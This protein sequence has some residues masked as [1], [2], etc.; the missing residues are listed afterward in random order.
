MTALQ[1]AID[2]AQL[3][4]D[5]NYLSQATV[6]AAFDALTQAIADFGAAKIAV[7]FDGL[8]A[9]ITEAKAI[10]KGNYNTATWNALQTAI[11]DAET[12]RGTQYVTQT[13]VDDAL[14]ALTA[15]IA[16]LRNNSSDGGGATYYTVTFDTDGGSAVK[17]VSVT[18]NGKVTKPADPT[19]DGY[20][21]GGW[22]ADKA[23]T[24]EFDFN[25]GITG[26]I[27]IYAK[28]TE[29][30]TVTPPEWENP[31]TDVKKSDWFYGDVE[32]VCENNLM[33]GTSAD[34]FSPNANLTRGMIVTILY[35][36]EGEL[37]V[38]GLA[39]PFTDVAAGQYYTDAIKWAVENKIVEGYG[40]GKFGPSDSITREQLAAILYRYMNYK[41]INLPV[42][43]QYIIFADEAD[44]S[45]YA[46]NAV[47]TFN[48]LGIIQGIGT[49]TAGQTIVN[50][51][52]NATRA[53]VAAMLHRFMKAIK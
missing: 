20:T 45:D 10:Q 5:D 34:M 49:N 50:P 31:F 12:V 18:Y 26:N 2:T 7:D 33:V 21:F 6:N 11:T 27:I 30:G 24:T 3:V 14:T 8:D 46:M 39:N 1:A 47:Q 28:W 22:Y 40:N 53:E 32:Y 43:E 37:G 36:L 23:L 51:K 48:K 42:T 41:K 25:K 19:K 15:A 44:I 13:A 16:G 29:D 17:S 9:K 4:A 38:S 52:G 35:R